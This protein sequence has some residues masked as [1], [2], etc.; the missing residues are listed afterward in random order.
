[1]QLNYPHT[2]LLVDDEVSILTALKRLFRRDG[3]DI[4]TADTGVDAL[5]K[6]SNS[7]TPVSLIIS[8]Q[9]MPTMTGTQFLEKAL[10]LAPEAMRFILTGYADLNAV[11]DAV[12]KGKIHYYIP[13]PWND[14]DLRRQVRAALAQVELRLENRRLTDLTERQNKE[15]LAL[16]E[17]LEK[18]VQERTWALQYQNKKIIQVNNEL[19]TSIVNTIRLLVSLV[20]SSNP[21]LGAYMKAVARLARDIAGEAGLNEARMNTIEMAGM[22]HDLGLLG[23]ADPVL[24]EEAKKMTREEYLSYSQHPNIAALSLSSIDRFSEIADIILAH[25]EH[26]D[27][28]GF[29][30]GLSAEQIRPESKILSLAADYQT[31]IHFW[32]HNTQRLLSLARRYLDAATVGDMDICSSKLR[33]EIA[34]RIILQSAG[35]RYDKGVVEVFEK[36]MARQRPFKKVIQIPYH[37]LRE[38]MT[39]M[40]D[41]RMADGRL[42]LASG[43]RLDA[44]KVHS[45]RLIADRNE[46]I[47]LVHAAEPNGSEQEEIEKHESR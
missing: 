1:M 17:T 34:E 12:N 18:K 15:L 9:R 7:P 8:D 14:D 16:N 22:V 44:K 37:L 23:L 3:F 13:K 42:L 10:A 40:R 27:G 6:L 39:I 32:P 24:D 5:E 25:H 41:L 26:V 33:Q 29:P 46:L 38:G 43:T 31:V 20:E 2:V 30:N 47:D 28:S 4:L 45:I 11:I 19:E 36:I 35:F 21:R